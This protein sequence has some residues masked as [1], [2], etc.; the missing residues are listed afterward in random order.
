MIHRFTEFVK[1]N[2]LFSKDSRVLLT[3]SGGIDSVVMADLFSKSGFSFGIAHCNFGLRGKESDADEEFTRDLSARY[4]VPFY[5]KRFDTK[6]FSDLL[7]ISVQM[8]ARELRYHWFE[9]IRS[10]LKYDCIATAH[11]LDDQSETFLI[12]LIRGTGISGLHGILPI[13]GWVVRPLLFCYREDI[14]SYATENGIRYREDSSNL[15]DKYLRNKI[16]HKIIPQLVELNPEF[17]K[18]LNSEIAILRGWEKIGR[19]DIKRKIAGLIKKQNGTTIIDLKTLKKTTPSELY[20]WEILSAFGFNSEAVS[21]VMEQ[22]AERSG[23]IFLSATHRA[24]TNRDSLIIEPFGISGDGSGRLISEKTKRISKPLGLKI[25]T[26]DYRKNEII[27]A[28]R[29]FASLDY[30]KLLFPLEI[31]K[32][33]PGD[34][35]HPFGMKGKKKVSDFLIDEKVSLPEKEQTYVLCSSG[36]IAW[37]IGRRIDQRFSITSKTI[38]ILRLKTI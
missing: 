10:S 11:H 31:R 3:V 5:T 28:G 38:K 16:R 7:K 4:K 22:S 23:R 9:E 37:V 36:K 18:T 14:I 15:Q 6:E 24:V 1:N 2:G 33:K 13:Q 27:P 26:I 17:R 34:S 29:E 35:F 21:L 20:A 30:D 25:S 19:K 8:A 32:W 12:N